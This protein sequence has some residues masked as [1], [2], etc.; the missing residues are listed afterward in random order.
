MMITMHEKLKNVP[1]FSH[2]HISQ[3]QWNCGNI[4]DMNFLT[5][6]THDAAFHKALSANAEHNSYLIYHQL[7]WEPWTHNFQTNF[8]NHFPFA[9]IHVPI[10]CRFS[11]IRII[12]M[13]QIRHYARDPQTKHRIIKH[14]AYILKEEIFPTKCQSLMP[15][16]CSWLVKYN[17]Q[18]TLQSC[19]IN[20]RLGG[21]LHGHCK[22]NLHIYFK[23]SN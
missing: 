13:S 12:V 2:S 8:P 15:E 16:P 10:S 1:E 19:D 5:I 6:L 23:P 3:S 17:T 22:T 21:R 4:I 18:N 20:C 9:H 14:H 11:D 7:R